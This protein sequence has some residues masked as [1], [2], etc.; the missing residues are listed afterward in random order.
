MARD[1]LT[2]GGGTPAEPS[3]RSAGY[4]SHQVWHS[5]TLYLD[6]CCLRQMPKEF[7]SKE[8]SILHLR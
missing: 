1:R 8:C 7:A 2:V 3:R 5:E 6:P 4:E